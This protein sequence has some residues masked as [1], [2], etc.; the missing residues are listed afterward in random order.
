MMKKRNDEGFALAY[1]VVVIFVLCSIAIAL[2]SS[3]LRTLQAQENMVQRMK[4]KYEAMGEIER[5]VA[6]LESELASN[7]YSGTGCS[8]SK[9]AYDTAID[10]ISSIISS[11]DYSF[12]DSI[13]DFSDLDQFENSEFVYSGEYFYDVTSEVGSVSVQA[14]VSIAFEFEIEDC[15]PEPTETDIL[16]GIYSL[17]PDFHYDVS[18][19]SPIFSLYEVTSSVESAEGG[20]V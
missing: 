7:S 20:A 16:N 10:T 15:T 9:D 8:D 3:T 1:V 4:D 17:P 18:I 6:E 11:S 5:L 2:M 14:N 13:D 19:S 12:V